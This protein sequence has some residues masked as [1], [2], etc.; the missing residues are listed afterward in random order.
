[1]STGLTFSPQRITELSLAGWVGVQG[2]RSF[3][4]GVSNV[5]VSN[6]DLRPIAKTPRRSRS[7]VGPELLAAAPDLKDSYTWR[8]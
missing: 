5:G 3:L 2:S 6:L 4:N 8:A 1:M 7:G